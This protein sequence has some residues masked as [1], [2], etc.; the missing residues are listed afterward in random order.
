MD[1]YDLLA[2]AGVVAMIVGAVLVHP[3]LLLIAA[4]AV[5]VVNAR[6]SA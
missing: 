2:A 1:R 6:P 4:G 5:A 3:A